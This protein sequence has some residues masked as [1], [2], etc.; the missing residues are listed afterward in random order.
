MGIINKRKYTIVSIFIISIFL[1]I[2]SFSLPLYGE[3]SQEGFPEIEEAI[4]EVHRVPPVCPYR[5]LKAVVV[6]ET[7][8][9]GD[10]DRQTIARGQALAG[11][12]G[13]FE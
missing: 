10:F 13:E 7:V 3:E 5:S 11:H 6:A 4:S 1:V 9:V 2:Y 8:V 12:Q